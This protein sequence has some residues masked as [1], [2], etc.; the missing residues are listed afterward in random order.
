MYCDESAFAARFSS[1]ELE[2]LLPDSDDRAYAVAAADADAIVDA[3]LSARYPVPFAT[4]PALVVGISADLTRY[5]LY[6]EAPPKE[7]TER[8]KLSIGMLE[9]LRDGAIVLPGQAIA[10]L[11][12]VA[13]S[14]R[15]QVF[16]EDEGC[17]FVGHL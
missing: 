4:P 10:D 3:Y 1:Q 15:Q 12:M 17:R 8:R 14:S 5:E 16:T 9:Q 6:E 11:S 2:Q 7:V 13:V